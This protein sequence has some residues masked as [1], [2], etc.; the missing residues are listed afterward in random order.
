LEN[1]QALGAQPPNPLDSGGWGLYPQRKNIAF[2]IFN[3][4]GRLCL[5]GMGFMVLMRWLP[6]FCGN[7]FHSFD[8]M[9]PGFCGN[10]L[11]F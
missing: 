8:E 7:G 3:Y 1:L 11:F 6:E 9:F 5:V 2:W 10:G 4:C